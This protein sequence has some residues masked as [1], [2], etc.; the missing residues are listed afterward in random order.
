MV[1]FIVMARM[2]WDQARTHRRVAELGRESI[3]DDPAWEQRA[4][5][6]PSK[7]ECRRAARRQD[8]AAWNRTVATGRKQDL[9]KLIAELERL[10]PAERAARRPSLRNQVWRLT[11]SEHDFQRVWNDRFERLVGR[12]ASQSERSTR[13]PEPAKGGATSRK[14][15]PPVRGALDAAAQRKLTTDLQALVAALPRRLSQRTAAQVL[16]GTATDLAQD[17]RRSCWS[18]TWRSFTARSLRSAIAQSLARGLVQ[19]HPDGTMMTASRKE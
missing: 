1:T 7:E 11:E 16:A 18:G 9:V 10:P 6:P 15:T 3:F 5:G 2:N 4:A 13:R 12:I 8:E 17:L 19:R 14:S